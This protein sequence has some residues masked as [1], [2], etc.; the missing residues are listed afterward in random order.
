MRLPPPFLVFTY[1]EGI[2]Q[3]GMITFFAGSFTLAP[4]FSLISNT[5]EIAIK[6]NQ[7]NRFERRRVAQGASGVGYWVWVM[8]VFAIICVPINVAIM[9]FTGEVFYYFD[10]EGKRTHEVSSS[11]QEWLTEYN[12]EWWTPMGTLLVAVLIEHAVLG[13]KIIIASI[14]PDV[15]DHVLA[16]ER[17]REVIEEYARKDLQHYKT[18]T[19]GKTWKDLK[20]E[21]ELEA[22]KMESQLAQGEAVQQDQMKRI[23]I[24]VL[25]AMQKDIN[26]KHKDTAKSVKNFKQNLEEK[27]R[28]FR[29]TAKAKRNVSDS[30]S[31]QSEKSPKMFR[32]DQSREGS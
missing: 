4:L 28:S 22:I 24:S 19:G 10:E 11:Y 30:E 26:H 27:M 21:M 5:L 15:P 14:I 25:D 7:I 17:K 31:E 16:K 29:D 6:L 8:E 32:E 18:S 12:P 2:I 20:Q 23:G 9:Y 13:L 3:F 1:A